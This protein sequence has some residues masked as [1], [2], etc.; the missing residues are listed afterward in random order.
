MF[1]LTCYSCLQ[2]SSKIC[3]VVVNDCFFWE[4]VIFAI[5][6]SSKD[7]KS[8]RTLKKTTIFWLVVW[9]M[10]FIV[11]FI[12]GIVLP[13]DELHH[14]SRWLLHHQ[15]VLDV[16]TSNLEDDVAI[17]CCHVGL[18]KKYGHFTWLNLFSQPS[19][20]VCVSHHCKQFQNLHGYHLVI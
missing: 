2:G 3:H 6:K 4:T 13:S 19:V 8:V 5:E 16:K 1:L 18:S 7:L 9:N 12:Y 11:H 10:N 17:R 14:F 15:P 20:C